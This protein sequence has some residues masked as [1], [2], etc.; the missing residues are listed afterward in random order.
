M[1][2]ILLIGLLAFTALSAKEYKVV[3]D[4]TSSSPETVT[5]RVLHNIDKL[6]HFYTK[7]GDTLEAAVVISGGAYA[8]FENNST[9]KDVAVAISR[10]SKLEVCSAGMKKRNIKPND[11]L[12]FVIPAFNKTEALIRYQNKGYA[13][14]P[15]Q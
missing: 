11:M 4:L 6:K 12:P 13:Y 3:F 14:I 2:K 1:I 15:V 10:I 8:F 5:K 9:I 7:K